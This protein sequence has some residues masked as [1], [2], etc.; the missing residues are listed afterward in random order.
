MQVDREGNAHEQEIKS[1]TFT[2]DTRFMMTTCVDNTYKFIP[3]IRAPGFMR[4]FFQYLILAFILTYAFFK[5]RE[6][7]FA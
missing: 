4:S 3:N 7:F 2:D 5:I 1:L 6:V